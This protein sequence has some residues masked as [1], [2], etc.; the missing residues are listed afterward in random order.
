MSDLNTGNL[1][2]NDNLAD[3]I[4]D[5]LKKEIGNQIR[6][7]REELNMSQAELAEKLDR[8][9]AYI[10]DLETGKTEPSITTLISLASLLQKPLVY[11]IPIG[12]RDPTGYSLEVGTLSAEESSLIKK[13]RSSS[14]VMD[15]RLAIYLVDAVARYIAERDL[16]LDNLSD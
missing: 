4:F 15:Y 16:N 10:S 5:R 9:Q 7:A 8:R 11:F 14:S 13:I 12:F 2:E 6:K 1:E 3:L